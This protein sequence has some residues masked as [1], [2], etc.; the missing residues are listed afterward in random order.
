MYELRD[1]VQFG[2]YYDEINPVRMYGTVIHIMLFS[3]FSLSTYFILFY[4]E[5]TEQVYLA[6]LS[7]S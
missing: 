2:S 3:L 5:C 1:N 4:V 7:I 6:L